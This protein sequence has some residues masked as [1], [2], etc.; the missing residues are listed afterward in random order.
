[1]IP[2]LYGPNGLI[3]APSRDNNGQLLIPNHTGHF[4]SGFQQSFSPLNTAIATQL[5]LL[6]IPSPASGFIYHEDPT[7]GLVSRST[8]SFGPI[9]SE[10]AE[11]IGKMKF[12]FGVA[13]QHFKFTSL[14]GQKL[15]GLPAVFTHDADANNVRATDVI[16]SNNSVDLTV[17]QTVLLMTGGITNGL[18]LSLAIPIVSTSMSARSNAFIQRLGTSGTPFTHTF[19]EGVDAPQKTFINSGSASGLGDIIVRVKGTVLN[20]KRVP[21]RLPPTSAHLAVTRRA[22]WARAP[23]V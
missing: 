22:S 15:S 10:R 20:R 23:G 14:D 18:D 16:T 5:T 12:S 1:M 6:P 3:L 17:H 13:Y 8:Q 2:G 9:L 11:T 19:V 21:L 7:T 4:N